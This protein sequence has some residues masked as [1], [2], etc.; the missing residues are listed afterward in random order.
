MW[1]L[2]PLRGLV[3]LLAG[4]GL[5]RVLSFLAIALLT[6]RLGEAGWAPV[7]VALTAV[8]F[9]ALFVE[10]GMRLY[11]AREV[12]RDP[13]AA[14]L[15]MRPVL[16]TQL[17]VAVALVAGASVIAGLG[18]TRPELGRLLPG[19]AVSLVALPFFVPWLFQ[20]LGTMQWVAVP[21]V[22]RYSAFL[23]LSAALV[24]S[25]LRV[26]WLPWVEAASMAGGAFI[27]VWAARRVGTPIRFARTRAFDPAVLREA[28]PIAA[29]QLLWVV[30]MYLPT[31]L[32]W[33]MAAEVSV[34]RFDVS[35]RV[36]MVL[37]ALLTMY[38]TNLYTPLS[39]DVR[40]PRR[41]FVGLLL[42]STGLAAA[43]AIL[44]T[45][46]LSVRPG[47]LL[48]VLNGAAF[49]N[50]E[51]AASLRIIALLVPV[52]AIRGH[53]HY[54]LI[55]LRR[56]R[57]EL[58]CAVAGSVLLVA[59]LLLWVPTGGAPAAARAMLVSESFGLVLTWVALAHTLRTA[60]G[61]PS[62]APA[63]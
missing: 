28:V 41:R 27:A 33:K 60:H 36:L 30:R 59:L 26:T 32:L 3:T 1:R 13:S 17:W 19:Y 63:A 46:A 4:E 24:T 50:P 2:P 62:A 57:R 11:G 31:A 54:A 9:G 44:A 10:S 37:Q 15:L 39:R 52:L 7:A 14:P 42:A 8:Q 25:P 35:H 58:G 16:S 22:A 47:A 43:T 12:A 40:G 38:L 18:L 55:A 49:D 56:Q 5:S 34:A 21:Q 45:A 6:R 61:P 29:S 48:G 23:L 20:G 51:A 53:A